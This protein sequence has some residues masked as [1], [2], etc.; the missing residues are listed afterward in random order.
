LENFKT[1]SNVYYPLLQITAK[2]SVSENF[3]LI[4]L[5]EL[6][7]ALN[8]FIKESGLEKEIQLNFP[9]CP[10]A[11]LEGKDYFFFMENMREKGYAEEGDKK[12]GID[13]VHV[14]VVL[15]EL[16]RFHST[17][18]AYIMSKAK[19]SSLTQVRL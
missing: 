8:Q 17:S 5:T 15:D 19:Q 3:F 16:A 4:P 18:H 11:K 12:L 14:K 7:P 13:A 1:W 2:S 6:F 10:Y 9:P